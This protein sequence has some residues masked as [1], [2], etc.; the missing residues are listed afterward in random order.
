[1]LQIYLH[2]PSG[3]MKLGPPNSLI[4]LAGEKNAERLVRPFTEPNFTAVNN[5]H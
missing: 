5:V 3:K 1:M 2:H 4:I